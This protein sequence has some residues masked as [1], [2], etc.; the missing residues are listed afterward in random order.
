MRWNSPPA[1]TVI[2]R[3]PDNNTC[4]LAAEVGYGYYGGYLGK[5]LAVEGRADSNADFGGSD[6]VPL[7]LPAPPDGH[8]RGIAHDP[9]GFAKMFDKYPDH[10]SSGWTSTSAIST[11]TFEPRLARPRTISS[12]RSTTILITAAL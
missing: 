7:L 5:D 3:S 1:A 11:R 10:T 4:R 2:S 9:T 12:S 6:D 8:D